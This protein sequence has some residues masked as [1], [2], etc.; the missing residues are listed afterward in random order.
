M[1]GSLYIDPLYPSLDITRCVKVV[2]K[3]L[4][5]SDLKF[6]DLNWMELGVYLSYHMTEDEM[7]EEDTREYCPK[8]RS[9]RGNPPKFTASGSPSQ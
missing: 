7:I 1:V 5:E 2:S 6:P 8:R 9:N 3:K 4:Y